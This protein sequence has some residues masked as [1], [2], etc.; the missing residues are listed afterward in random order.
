MKPITRLVMLLAALA[1]VA[2]LAP[3]AVAET[4]HKAFFGTYVGRSISVVG[5]DL[6]E[7]DFNVVIGPY[8]KTGFQVQWTTVIR[9]TNSS[10]TTQRKSHKASFLPVRSRPG[11]YYSVAGK[12]V[13]GSQVPADPLAGEPYVWAGIEQ[14]TLTISAL[15]I[16]DTGGYEVQVYK[17]TLTTGGMNTDFERMRDGVQLRRITGRLEKVK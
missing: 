15:Y 3:P 9:Y 4:D 16:T 10:K 12:D 17:R 7:R 13:F 8:E 1:L 2:G 6:S 5:E 14:Q 11:L